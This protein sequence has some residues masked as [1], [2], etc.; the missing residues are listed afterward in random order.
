MASAGGMTF[1]GAAA[2]LADVGFSVTG[3]GGF[4]LSGTAA[5]LASAQF[6]VL[7]A[8]GFVLGG[9]ADTNSTGASASDGFVVLLRRRRR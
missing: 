5:A 9:S 6:V 8:G 3:A 4:V 2:A 1:G 7:P